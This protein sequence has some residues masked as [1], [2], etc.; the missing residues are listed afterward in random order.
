M[1][2]IILD[3]HGGPEI[4]RAREVP[5]PLPGLGEVRVRAEAVGV[6]YADVLS[7]KGWYGWAPALPYTLGME[8]TGTIDM[9]GDGIAERAVGERVIVGA[10][11]GAYAEQIVVPERQAL[12]AIPGFSTEENAALAVNYLT[13]WVALSVRRTAFQTRAPDPHRTHGVHEDASQTAKPRDQCCV[14]TGKHSFST[15][16]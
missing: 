10:Q 16:L 3:R 1:R 7:R 12:P 11:H 5:N 6:N 14:Q 8:A 4:L 13:A 9:L 15:I 2:A